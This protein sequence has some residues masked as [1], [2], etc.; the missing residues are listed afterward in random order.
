MAAVYHE[1][2]EIE[3]GYGELKTRL[4]GAAFQASGTRLPGTARAARR[5]PSAVHA[6]VRSGPGRRH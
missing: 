6:E 5:L 3:N 4:R 2:W 1:R